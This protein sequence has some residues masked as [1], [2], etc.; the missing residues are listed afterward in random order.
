MMWIIYKF[1]NQESIINNQD[2]RPLILDSHHYQ[3]GNL[4]VACLLLLVAMNLLGA[5][6]M[7]T[8]TREYTVATYK[9]VDSQVFQITDSC[10]N[11][12]ITYFEGLSSRPAT[13]DPITV[14]DLSYMLTG[15]ETQKQ[16]NKLSGYSYGCTVDYKTSKT[17]ATSGTGAGSEIGG[18]GGAYGATAGTI[19][20]D[21]YQ[22]TSTGLGPNSSTRTVYTII[23]VSY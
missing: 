15:N 8:S 2:S 17:S 22:V 14:S 4:L 12:V 9:A 5:G 13:V 10:K 23:S 6:L 21:Y 1:W 19:T 16:Q 7:H 3:K 20:E 11:D 18:A